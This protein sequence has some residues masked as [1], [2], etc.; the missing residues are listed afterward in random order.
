MQISMIA[1]MAK[2]RVIGKDNQ[3]PWHLPADLA[4]FKK[5]TLNKPI[6]MGHKT[7]KSIGRALP[8]R[9]N[10]VLT[11][12]KD[13][14]I[15]NVIC[16]TSI[17]AAIKIATKL[18]CEELMIIGG[19]TVYSKFIHLVS[20]LYLTFIELETPGD[21]YF[22]DFKQEGEWTEIYKQTYIADNKN[23]YNYSFNIYNKI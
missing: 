1:A 5:Q 8:K 12:N 21:T 14:K 3:M 7:F 23:P 13:L 11:K 17:D 4:W 22:P 18:E 10:I 6:L 19:G 15:D 9:T 20:K 16:V 2:N